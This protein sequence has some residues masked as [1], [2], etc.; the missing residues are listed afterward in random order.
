MVRAYAPCDPASADTMTGD[1][2][3]AC[4]NPRPLS[5]CDEDPEGAIGVGRLGKGKLR[6]K[7]GKSGEAVLRGRF[8]GLL[9]CAGNDFTG[10]VRV[11]IIMRITLEDPACAGG[12]CTTVDTAFEVPMQVTSGTG[13]LKGVKLPGVPRGGGGLVNAEIVRGEVRDGR[14]R[15]V[16]AGHGFFVR[17]DPRGGGRFF[18]YG[19]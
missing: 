1:G 5:D 16:L 4:A 12:W 15:A 7:A 2:F 18:C 11:A 6:V 13:T 19:N 10:S 14:G 17:C 9:D 3:P 8:T